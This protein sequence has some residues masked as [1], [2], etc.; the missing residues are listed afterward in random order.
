MAEVGDLA[1]DLTLPSNTGEM[2]TLSELLKVK[3]VLQEASFFSVLS[4]TQSNYAHIS[5][6]V[7]F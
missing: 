6:C 4:L 7:S 5:L 3:P 1:I 2:V